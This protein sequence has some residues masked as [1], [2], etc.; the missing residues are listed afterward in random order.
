MTTDA[1]VSVP[2]DPLL[3][4]GDELKHVAQRLREGFE[5]PNHVGTLQSVNGAL[6]RLLVAAEMLNLLVEA[7]NANMVA[8]VAMVKGPKP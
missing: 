4:I 2:F 1:W 6:D 3:R 7:A 5:A 8:Q